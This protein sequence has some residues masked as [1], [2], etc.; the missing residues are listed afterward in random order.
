MSKKN[1][2]ILYDWIFHVNPYTDKVEATTRDNYHALFS[3][4]RSSLIIGNTF[5]E[6][7]KKIKNNEGSVSSKMDR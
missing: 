2:L 4:K 7:I 1:S 6:V 3:G 5:T